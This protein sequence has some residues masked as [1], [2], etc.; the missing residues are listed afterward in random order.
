M[1]TEYALTELVNQDLS[2]KHLGNIIFLVTWLICY[3]S[4]I[5]WLSDK[6]TPR[7]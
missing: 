4:F 2:A 1:L 7:L 6:K 3:D 5:V